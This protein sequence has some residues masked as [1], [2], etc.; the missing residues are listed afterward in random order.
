MGKKQFQPG[1]GAAIE[2]KACTGLRGVQGRTRKAQKYPAGSGST[3]LVAESVVISHPGSAFHQPQNPSG[4]TAVIVRCSMRA[5][6]LPGCP[7]RR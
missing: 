5:S 1:S 4:A 2:Q 7:N 3:R 6:K